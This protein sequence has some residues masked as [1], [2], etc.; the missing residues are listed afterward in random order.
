MKKHLILTAAL[1]LA[2]ISNLQAADKAPN[3]VLILAD[4]LGGGM[5]GCYGQQVITTPN[6]DRLAQQGI[7]FNNYHASVFCAPSRWSLLTGMHDGRIGGWEYTNGGLAIERELGNISEEEYQKQFAQLQ[8]EAQTIEPSE[9]FLAQI[10][11]RAGYLTAQFG[12]LDSGFQTW[13]ERVKRFGWDYYNGYYCHRR[14]HGYY[15]PYLWRNGVRYE[16]EGNYDPECGKMSREG[17][18]PMSDQRG[19]TFSQNVFIEEILKFI[20]DNKHRPFFLYHPSQLPHGPASIP[21]LHPEVANNPNLSLVEKKYAS[22]VKM[23]DDHV[24]LIL[25]ELEK[26]GIADN[27]IVVFASDNGHDMYYGAA[28]ETHRLQQMPDGS[29]TN[30]TDNKWRTSTCGD[31]F[32]GGAGL[33]GQKGSGYQ[34]GIQ[35]PMIMRWPG[36][37]K[38]GSETDLL[39]THYDFMATLA[40]IGGVEIPEGKDSISYLPTLLGKPQETT[41]DYIVVQNRKNRMGSS[42]VI[43]R[44]GWKLL[45]VGKK[46]D[47]FQLYNIYKDPFEN[48]ELSAVYPEKVE[49]LKKILKRE[50]ESERPDLM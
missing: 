4:D 49:Q 36:R 11:Q 31:V 19:K 47:Q 44:G 37:I 28:S 48:E 3:I 18:E 27:T 10:A 30:L 6:I 14:C 39:T 46:R 24:G 12:K 13:H 8:A 41:H 17:L 20:R 43:D 29:P 33:A 21:A 34:G 2:A 25:D 35:C 23:L 7:K 16:L 42:S 40:D 1:L 45:E 22:M 9:V 50:L 5:L 32:N 15:P 38:A 26:Q